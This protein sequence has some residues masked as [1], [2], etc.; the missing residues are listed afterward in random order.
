MHYACSP[1]S[2]F[3][4][5]VAMEL[6]KIDGNHADANRLLQIYEASFP[7]NER[8]ESEKYYEVL[9]HY[10]VDIYGIYDNDMLIGLVN[11]ITRPAYRFIYLWYFALDEPY[12]NKGIGSV[13]LERLKELYPDCQLVLDMEPLDENA[14]NYE[15]R[16]RRTRFY[17]RHGLTLT[18]RCMTYFDNTFEIM[19]TQ[20]PFR[21]ADFRK[22]F[23]EPIFKDWQPIF[24]DVKSLFK[25]YNPT[26]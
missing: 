17:T 5:F 9:K 7:D 8:I 6:K 21:E 10:S 1:Q 24:A 4:T 22:M 15:V 3:I 25:G 26:L 11:V 14:P 23:N 20:P 19:C 2:I 12:R 13:V 16:K 18:G